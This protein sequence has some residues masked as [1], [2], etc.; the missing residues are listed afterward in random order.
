VDKARSRPRA[1]NVA[2]DLKYLIKSLFLPERPGGIFPEES[3]KGY[4]NPDRAPG[5][6][7]ET[8]FRGM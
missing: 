2:N 3:I 4:N 1:I 8:V 5:S 7:E 6:R